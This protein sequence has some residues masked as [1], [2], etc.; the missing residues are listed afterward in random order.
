LDFGLAKAVGSEGMDQQ[1]TVTEPGRVIGTPDGYSPIQRRDG[2]RHAGQY[3]AN[4]T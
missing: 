3:S 2:F 1:S 4:R